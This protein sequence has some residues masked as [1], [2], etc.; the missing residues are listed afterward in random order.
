MY[1]SDENKRALDHRDALNRREIFIR[2]RGIE[3]LS[4]IMWRINRCALRGGIHP[5]PSPLVPSLTSAGRQNA[6]SE[7]EFSGEPSAWSFCSK[8]LRNAFQSMPENGKLRRTFKRSACGISLCQIA[9]VCRIDPRCLILPASFP[10][11]LTHRSNSPTRS[12]KDL[13]IPMR[14]FC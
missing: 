9:D 4:G 7:F 3:G 12:D 6:A 13:R 5:V 2:Y 11:L 10:R 1:A 8:G 14:N